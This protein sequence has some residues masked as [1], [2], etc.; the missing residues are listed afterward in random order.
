M[1]VEGY[2]TQVRQD[3]KATCVNFYSCLRLLLQAYLHICR[4][5]N[6]CRNR[7]K[8]VQGNFITKSCSI[9]AICTS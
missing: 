6:V 4:T 9:F 2:K 8:S 7:I 1:P 5:L 3:G